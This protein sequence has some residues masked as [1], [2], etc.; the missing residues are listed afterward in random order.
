MNV[1]AE[2]GC[3]TLT[4]QTR[5]ETHRKQ[6]RRAEDQRRPSARARGYDTKWERTRRNYL[7]AFPICQHSAGC[8]N[9]AVDVHHIDGAGPLGDRGH[10]WSNLQGLCK[11]HHSKVTATDQPGGWA[12]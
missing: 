3:P 4:D 1:C 6:K 2:P 7:A 10:D 5:C 12:A 11:P 9:P 8:L